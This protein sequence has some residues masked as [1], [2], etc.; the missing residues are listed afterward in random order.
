MLR[1]LA[2]GDARVTEIAAP[3]SM[4]LNAV[5]KHVRA[6]ERA[7]LV[8]RRVSGRDHYIGLA[9]APLH[10]AAGWL[11]EARLSGDVVEGVRA[12][13]ERLDH[14]TDPRPDP[15]RVLGGLPPVQ[16]G[17]AEPGSPSA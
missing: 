1:R 8:R 14:R 2:L 7:G 5:S 13:R 3:F 4:S 15:R 6:L 11:D 16:L 9:A 12:G 10:K 17:G